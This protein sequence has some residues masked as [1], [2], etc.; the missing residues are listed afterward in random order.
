M[1]PGA[2]GKSSSMLGII[3]YI[4]DTMPAME[5]CFCADLNS[6]SM[7]PSNQ[8]GTHHTSGYL[9]LPRDA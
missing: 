8:E 4:H 9:Q 1:S 3:A 5:S 7:D 2:P 6:R